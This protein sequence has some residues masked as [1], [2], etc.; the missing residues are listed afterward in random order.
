[1]PRDARLLNTLR[2]ATLE[3][4]RNLDTLVLVKPERNPE[5]ARLR[6]E[7]GLFLLKHHKL[8]AAEARTALSKAKA[9]SRRHRF[10][11]AEMKQVAQ[12]AAENVAACRKRHR[13]LLELARA[14]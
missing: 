10:E 4:A 9:S 5:V 6:F 1:M 8:I 3:A 11:L 7:L 2:E 13:H 14:A 12:E